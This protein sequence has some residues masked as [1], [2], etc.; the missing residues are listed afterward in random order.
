STQASASSL[1]STDVNFGGGVV[2]RYRVETKPIGFGVNP[3]DTQIEGIAHAGGAVD[4]GG[5]NEGFYA[6]DEAGLQLALSSILADAVK[7]ESCNGL[8][9]DCDG[10]IDEDFPVATNGRAAV[11]CDN[12]K[13]GVCKRTGVL[14][15]KADGTGVVCN[16]ADGGTGSAEVCNG[17]DDDCDGK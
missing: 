5:V 12:G 14:V 8:D 17:L 7:T 6:S 9:D 11:A 2:R 10:L 1:L 16:A 3:G 4:V 13:L 15:C